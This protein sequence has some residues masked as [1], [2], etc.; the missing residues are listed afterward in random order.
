MKTSEFE[1]SLPKEFINQEP[2]CPRDA[3]KLLVLDRKKNKVCKD[4]FRNIADYFKSGDVLVLND[5]KVI[6]AR[7]LARKKSGGK[8]EVFLLKKV[9]TQKNCCER[10]EALVKP[11]SKVPE[12][13]YLYIGNDIEIKILKKTDEG[14]RIIEFSSS[15]ILEKVLKKY[16]KIPL[17]PYIKK[18]LSDPARYQTIYAKKNGSVAAPTAALHFTSELLRKIKNKG[19]EIVYIT[20]HMGLGSFRPIKEEIIENHKMP[21]EY[22]Q[23]SKKAAEKINNAQIKG[24]RIIACGTDAVRTLE[25]AASSG[26]LKAGSGMTSLFIT[27]DYEFKVVDILITNL[28]LP[29]SSHL[30]LVSAFADKKFVFKAYKYAMA[31]KFRFYTFGDATI[32]I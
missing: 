29:R 19:I 16:G 14:G 2:I 22:Y 5:T 28:H 20:L 18:T 8:V 12:E 7:I 13:S 4:N 26:K 21:F 31:E 15:I 23:L 3:S 11:G 32:I 17:P 24:N 30:V 10:W 6:P 1:Y 25:T 27:E 9:E